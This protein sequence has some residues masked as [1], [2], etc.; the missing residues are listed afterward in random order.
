MKSAT[1]LIDLK[2][3]APHMLTPVVLGPNAAGFMIPGR[4]P[5]AAVEA[6]MRKNR[7]TIAQLARKMGA[8]ESRVRQARREGISGWFQCSQWLQA[9][10]GFWFIPQPV[11]LKAARHNRRRRAAA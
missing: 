11:A 1:M 8:T 5:P 3:P 2:S 7:L 4:I 6:L 9:I 10:T